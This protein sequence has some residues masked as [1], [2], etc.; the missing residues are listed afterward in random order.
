[1]TFETPFVMDGTQVDGET[2]RRAIGTL[3]T[4]WGI[5]SPGDLA[6]TQQGTPAMSVLMGVGAA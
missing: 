5:V 6:V 1:M 4:A 2:I 3:I